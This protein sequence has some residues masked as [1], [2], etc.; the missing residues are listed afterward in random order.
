MNDLILYII[1]ST[2][3]TAVFQSFYLLVMRKTTFFR[4]NRIIFIVGTFL[5]MFLPFVNIEIPADTMS[6]TPMEMIEA[7]I[8]SD[9]GL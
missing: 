9:L 6:V 3:Y 8:V 5:C 7:A 1:K 4:L 2:I